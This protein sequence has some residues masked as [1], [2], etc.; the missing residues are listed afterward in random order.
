MS[1]GLLFSG[2]LFIDRLDANGVKQGDVGPLNGTEVAIINQAPDTKERISRMPDS[3]GQ[4]LDVVNLPKPQQVSVTI[5]SVPSNMLAMAVYGTTET[6]SDGAGTAV[7]LSVVD[8]NVGRWYE[9]GKRN[10]VAASVVI[11]GKTEGDDFE[12]N[13]VT[14]HVRALTAGTYVDGDDIT[15]TFDHA[16]VTGSR[17]RGGNSVIIKARLRL[18]GI[19]MADPEG[20]RGELIV[21]EATLQSDENLD[22][23]SGEYISAKFSGSMRTLPGKTQPFIFDHD[24][25]YA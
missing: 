9:M 14:G 8:I 4:A 2:A 18:S 12:V 23:S 16:A 13:Y 1:S 7:A 6:L 20:K 15:G 3:F 21:D 10:I 22:L 17:I 24:L 25:A 11:A 5:D 19:N